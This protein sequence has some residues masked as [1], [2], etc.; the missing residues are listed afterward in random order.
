MLVVKIELHSAITGKTTVLGSA[1]IA[2]DGGTHSRADYTVRV[3]RKP[4]ADN[5]RL[6]ASKPLRRGYVENYPRKSYN[7]WRL[8][9]RSLLAAFPEERA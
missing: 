6:V 2:N 4:H 1:I 9:I 7:V 5:L 8:V 3:G